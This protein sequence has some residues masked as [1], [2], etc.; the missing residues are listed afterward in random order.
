[1]EV[2][3][4]NCARL[5]N[6]TGNALT[7]AA[8][9]TPGRDGTGKLVSREQMERLLKRLVVPQRISLKVRI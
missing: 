2:E 6:L 3:N 9:D 4:A 8:T 7:F 1:M 5:A